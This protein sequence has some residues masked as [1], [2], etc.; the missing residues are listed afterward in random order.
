MPDF[1]NKKFIP[2]L[3]EKPLT[4][5]VNIELEVDKRAESKSKK[6]DDQELKV[7]FSSKRKILGEI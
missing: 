4:I 2:L 7:N 6:K 3:N 1:E 5:P